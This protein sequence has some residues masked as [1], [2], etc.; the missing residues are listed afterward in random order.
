MLNLSDI[1]TPGVYIDEVPKFPPSVAQVETA[2]PAFIGYTRN[3]I[4]NGDTLINRPIRITS[5]VEYEAI[6]GARLEGFITAV[7]T[8]TGVNVIVTPARSA[9]HFL[10]LVLFT[11]NVFC[12]WRRALLHCIDR[13][14][15]CS[16]VVDQPHRWT[17]R[18]WQGR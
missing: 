16:D 7:N 18:C 9:G 6:Y 4:L 1:K 12:Q 13:R 3:T 11:A 17:S 15:Q 10:S 5:M 8:V 2:I 14:R